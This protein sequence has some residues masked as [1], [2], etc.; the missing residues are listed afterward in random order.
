MHSKD[1]SFHHITPFVTLLAQLLQR[2]VI[3]TFVSP[4][5]SK[6]TLSSTPDYVILQLEYI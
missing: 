4:R 1:V 6:E 2:E 5:T 3:L